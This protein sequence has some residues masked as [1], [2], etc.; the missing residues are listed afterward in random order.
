MLARERIGFATVFSWMLRAGYEARI[1]RPDRA[2]SSLRSAISHADA[3]D[4]GLAAAVSRW[5]FGSLIQGE[6]GA[7]ARRDAETWMREQDIRAPERMVSV[8]LPGFDDER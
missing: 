8:M 3:V 6:D 5:R 1:G 7:L 4:M 2:I